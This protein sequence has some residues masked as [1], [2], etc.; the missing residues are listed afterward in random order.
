MRPGPNLAINARLRVAGRWAASAWLAVQLAVTLVATGRAGAAEAASEYGVKAALL[1][2]F[3]QYYLKWPIAAFP[4]ANSP[5]SIGVL[6][7]DPFGALLDQLVQGVEVGSERRKI[8][9]KRSHKA[10]ELKSCHMV[11]VCSSEKDRVA[12]ELNV[13]GG[14]T[15][16]V[17]EIDG[18]A[19]RGGAI[20]FYIASEKVRFEINNDAAKQ[21]GITISADLIAASRPAH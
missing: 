17:G 4:A 3:T 15:L 16:T 5:I 18:F 2:K 12:Q 11:F 21:R 20:N 19:D 6:G 8:V 1:V 13:L 14:T 9:I 10:D 7:D